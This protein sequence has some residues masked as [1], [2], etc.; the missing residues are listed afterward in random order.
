MILDFPQKSK[1]VINMTEYVQRLLSNTPHD[2]TGETATPDAVHL[3]IINPGIEKLE[4]STAVV[5]HIFTA[6]LLF[7]CKLSQPDIQTTVAFLTTTRVKFLDIDDRK[8]LARVIKH[9]HHT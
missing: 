9:L 8:K 6:K 5:F 4:E 1:V 2:M 7:L 3:F